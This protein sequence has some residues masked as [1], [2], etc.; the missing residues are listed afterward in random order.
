MDAFD[1]LEIG[2][3]ARALI[4]TDNPLRLLRPI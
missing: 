3:E 2:E 1:K 4:L